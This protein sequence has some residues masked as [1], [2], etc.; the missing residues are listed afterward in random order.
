MSQF[1]AVSPGSLTA[2]QSGSHLSTASWQGV[3]GSDEVTPKPPLLQAYKPSSPRRSSQ[4]VFSS[5]FRALLPFTV[6]A[7]ATPKS[8]GGQRRRLFTAP[9]TT[10]RQLGALSPTP[11]PM[12]SRAPFPAALTA[13]SP[14][15][16][17]IPRSPTSRTP[18]SLT[19]LPKLHRPHGRRH[20]GV[21]GR[22]EAARGSHVTRP[23]LPWRPRP[24]A[25]R[26]QEFP[27]NNRPGS[28]PSQPS[29][30]KVC[31]QE[32]A[33]LLSAHRN[34]WCP[35]NCC[36]GCPRSSGLC[37]NKVQLGIW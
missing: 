23:A 5:P 26:C 18:T 20:L 13:A 31:E 10:A 14:R 4:H 28:L 30:P 2:E 8:R 22:P 33:E 32:T 27:A 37:G 9:L 34:V 15:R 11:L 29:G 3:V 6:N 35:A 1:K 24:P 19:R 36:S 7:P 12:A 17:S 16:G 25:R 21:R